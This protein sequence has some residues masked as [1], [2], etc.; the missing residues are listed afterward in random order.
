MNDSLIATIDNIENNNN[1]IYFLIRDSKNTPY[2]SVS[3]IY[4]IASDL[5]KLGKNIKIVHTRGDYTQP[6]WFTCQ[7]LPHQNLSETAFSVE[8]IFVVTELDIP[9]LREMVKR[10][11]SS[12][13]VILATT[14]EFITD[15][16]EVGETY[17]N[18]NVTDTIVSSE[19]S[20]NYIRNIFPNIRVN[21]INPG[22]PDIF[23]NKERKPKLL[24]IP[25]FT[26][27]MRDLAKLIK[28]FRLR[29]PLLNSIDFIQVSGIQEE[30]LAKLLA[31]SFVAVSLDR[32][33]SFNTF[34]IES[35]LSN[36]HLIGL[37]PFLNQDFVN[38]KSGYWCF[39]VEEIVEQLTGY[40]YAFLDGQ[41]RHDIDSEV[42][43]NAMKYSENNRFAQTSRIFEQLIEE[44]KNELISALNNT[45]Q[46]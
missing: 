32:L 27:D 22:I 41:N 7:S 39:S 10:G 11:V 35:Q 42:L 40:V 4:R 44:R 31:E 46:Q 26:R 19:N 33:G 9:L 24:Q 13:I 14:Y 23:I 30:D 2:S 28:M 25:V 5:F 6:T 20:G 29:N 12:K 21:L 36:T 8:D 1:K 17:S 37:M 15:Q 38:E 16:L 43:V 45:N 3:H 34:I 18:F